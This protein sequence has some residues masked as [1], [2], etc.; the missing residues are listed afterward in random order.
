MYGGINSEMLKSDTKNR[1]LPQIPSS[2]L[3]EYVN[4]V[5]AEIAAYSYR[6]ISEKKKEFTQNTVNI[7]PTHLAYLW[8]ELRLNKL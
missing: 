4:I 6:H 5:N 3:Y 2:L 1:R 7:P 8:F